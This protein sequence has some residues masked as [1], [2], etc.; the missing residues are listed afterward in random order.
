MLADL[1][2]ELLDMLV[3]LPGI[4]VQPAQFGEGVLALLLLLQGGVRVLVA[5]R[6][7][8]ADGR[9]EVL[10]LDRLVLGQP[11]RDHVHDGFAC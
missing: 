6:Q 11:G 2:D 9:P 3:K 4:R 7:G 10:F 1:E 8:F 5:V